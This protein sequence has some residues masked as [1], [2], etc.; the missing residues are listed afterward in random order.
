MF[1]KLFIKYFERCGGCR[2]FKFTLFLK[3][4][5]YILRDGRNSRITSNDKLCRTCFKNIKK[6]V[7]NQ[8][9]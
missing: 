3:H 1:K 9:V 4:R 5:Q 2:Q 8:L 7:G 6:M